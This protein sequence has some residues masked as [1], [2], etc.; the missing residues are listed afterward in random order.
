VIIP[1]VVI[2]VMIVGETTVGCE[3]LIFAEA[4]VIAEASFIVASPFPIFALA[5]TVEPV[6]L[7]IVIPPLCQPL[8]VIR[9]IRSVIAA[10][11]AVTGIR[12]VS[13]P[14]LRASGRYDCP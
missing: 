5:L 7:D 2:A 13:I 1:A 12:I 3:A 8:A 10:V 6:V 14:V 11:P 4:R 9:I